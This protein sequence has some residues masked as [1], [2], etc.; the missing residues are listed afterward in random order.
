M[1]AAPQESS[2]M[3]AAPYKTD[4]NNEKLYVASCETRM[5]YLA[6]TWRWESVP[7]SNGY[8]LDFHVYTRKLFHQASPTSMPSGH[9][10]TIKNAIIGISDLTDIC[11]FVSDGA[12]SVPDPSS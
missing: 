11:P 6:F 12:C 9:V 7:E 4:L 2:E 5:N 1:S 10:I 8:L 3:H